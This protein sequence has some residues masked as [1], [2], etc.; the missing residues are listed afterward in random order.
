MRISSVSGLELAEENTTL[1]CMNMHLS[2]VSNYSYRLNSKKYYQP[3]SE[4]TGINCHRKNIGHIK[5]VHSS[6][7][8]III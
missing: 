7:V 2:W 6:D 1:L 5:Q 3:K 4:N 8:E